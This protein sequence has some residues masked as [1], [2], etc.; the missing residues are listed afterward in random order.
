MSA[1][2]ARLGACATSFSQSW[3]FAQR[4]QARA[5]AADQGVR[6]TSLA[7]FGKV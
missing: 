6:P 2:T 3:D 4:N 5:T 1:N 7:G